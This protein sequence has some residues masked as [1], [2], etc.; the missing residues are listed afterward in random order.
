MIK[1]H[2]IIKRRKIALL[3]SISLCFILYASANNQTPIVKIESAQ[4]GDTIEPVE[5]NIQLLYASSDQYSFRID[6]GNGEFSGWTDFHS[7]YFRSTKEYR[8]THPGTY[9]YMA[10]VKNKDFESE[11]SQPCTVTIIPNILKWKIQTA[12]GIYSAPAIDKSNNIYFSCEEGTINCIDSDGLT[13]WQHPLYSQVYSSPVIGKKAIYVTTASGKLYALDFNGK[14]KWQFEINSPCYTT[15]AVNNK[16]AIFFG[17]DNATLYCVSQKGN[18]IWQYK[19]GDEISGSPVIDKEGNVYIASD[20]VYSFNQKGKLKWLYQPSDEDEIYFFASPVIGD[21]GNIYIGHTEGS[22]VALTNKGRIKWIAPTPE[23]DPIRSAIVIDIDNNL[24]FG[25]EN[26]IIH[27]KKQHQDIEQLF[28][29]D[30]YIF[31]SPAIDTLSNIYI[32]SDDGF[33]YCINKSGKLLYKRQIAE[34]SKEIMYSSSPIISDN[35]TVY[36]GSWEGSL[37]AFTGFAPPM[38][39]SWPLYRYNQ[40]N[41]GCKL[42]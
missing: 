13:K 41:T 27:I 16:D 24:F 31:A 12:S 26:G 10:Q 9:I 6:F 34:D 8:Y 11:W 38:K 37:Y 39:S 18:L 42:K 20:A 40:Q 33:F 22:L 1:A 7:N 23:E 5:F 17:C 35:G 36:V 15:P 30:Y 21:D 28:E 3:L 25:D 14:E 19:T 2:N 4:Y 29:T 32:T